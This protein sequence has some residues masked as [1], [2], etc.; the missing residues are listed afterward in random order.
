MAVK[1]KDADSPSESH[2]RRP[3]RDRARTKSKAA[4]VPM[5]D[6]PTLGPMVSEPRA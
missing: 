6:P 3:F 5:A 1:R 2:S 4:V